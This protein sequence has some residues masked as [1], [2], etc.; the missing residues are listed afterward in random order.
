MQHKN[1]AYPVNTQKFSRRLG[2]ALTAWHS[3]IPPKT[4]ICFQSFRLSVF[5]E[6]LWVMY[7]FWLSF[8]KLQLIS[9]K[10]NVL[11]LCST[12]ASVL[13]A[14]EH[15]I[16]LRTWWKAKMEL[17][18]KWI[19]DLH[20]LYGQILWL[21]ATANCLLTCSPCHCCVFSLL[22]CPQVVKFQPVQL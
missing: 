12:F 15:Y 13:A 3:S 2:A 18:Q 6:Y 21:P 7:L 11:G 16:F 22:R 19:L 14:K 17:K 10:G 5:A 4:C 1:A 8:L 9:Y 20:S